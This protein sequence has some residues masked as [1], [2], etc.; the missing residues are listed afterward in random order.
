MSKISKL[1]IRQVTNLRHFADNLLLSK[2]PIRQV[3]S[4]RYTNRPAAVSKLP[5]RQVTYPVL[6]GDWE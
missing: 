3:T 2:L 1:P 6:A 5:I 4:T